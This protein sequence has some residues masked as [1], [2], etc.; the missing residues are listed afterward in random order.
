MHFIT[1]EEV[2]RYLPMKDVISVLEEAFEDLANG[3]SSYSS[4]GRLK[5]SEGALVTMPGYFNKYNVAGLKTYVGSQKKYRYVLMFNSVSG[6]PIALIE[7]SRMGQIKTGALPA[8]VT[9]KMVHGGSHS[10]GILGSGLQARGQ[11]EGI[12]A[13]FPLDS[14]NVYSRTPGNARK[15]AEEMSSKFGIDIKVHDTASSALKNCSIISSATSSLEPIFSRRDLGDTYHVN[16]IGANVPSRREA[17]V[18]VLDQSDCVIVEDMPQALEESA[19]IMGMKDRKKCIE[20]VDLMKMNSNGLN[21][22]KR[23]VFKS[24]GVGLE[25][26][27]AGYALL[28]NMKIL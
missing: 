20:L 4:R 14:V 8:M 5:L 21:E 2:D 11:L 22:R 18:D 28:K 27:A 3:K 24:M 19:E 26:V 1:E 16:L 9:K 10:L 6:E 13:A 23:T 12:L 15:F 17:A 25:D 7:S